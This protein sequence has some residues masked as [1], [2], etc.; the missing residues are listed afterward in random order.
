MKTVILGVFGLKMLTGIV[1]TVILKV[2]GLEMLIGIVKTVT[3]MGF[4]IQT[5]DRHCEKP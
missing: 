1:K 5:S 3:L 2:L 4:K